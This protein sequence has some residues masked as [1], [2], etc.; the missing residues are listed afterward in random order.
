MLF[1]NVVIIFIILIFVYIITYQFIPDENLVSKDH[2]IQSNIL[3]HT[4]ND[5]VHKRQYVIDNQEGTF[6]KKEYDMKVISHP[7]KKCIGNGTYDRRIDNCSCPPGFTYDETK[8]CTPIP[9]VP[10]ILT[11]PPIPTITKCNVGYTLDKTLNTCVSLCSSNEHFDPI[12]NVCVKNCLSNERLDPINN[13]CVADCQYGDWDSWSSCVSGSLVR[14]RTRKTTAPKN[15]GNTCAPG[16]IETDT[17]F[18]PINCSYG[19]WGNWSSCLLDNSTATRTRITY[20]PINNG[21]ACGPGSNIETDNSHCTSSCK[22]GAWSDWSA[23]QSGTRT[24]TRTLTQ[25][26]NGGAACP[27]SGTTETQSDSNTCTSQYNFIGEGGCT[28]DMNSVYNTCKNI[29]G[30]Q[31]YGQQSN[32]CWHCLQVVNSGGNKAVSSYPRGLFNKDPSNDKTNDNNP[33]YIYIGEGGCTNDR[34]SAK[35]TCK[36]IAGCNY[37]GQQFNGCWHCLK[38]VTSGGNKAASSYPQGLFDMQYI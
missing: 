6:M 4:S 16:I 3:S 19:T 30:F 11:V 13:V 21:T 12:N 2:Y 32:G 23:C 1:N 5:N 37:I 34:N 31:K 35:N 17:S 36:A 7:R 27:I 29:S 8:G 38:S 9:T 22:Y 24:R 26:I 15:G 33:Q 10:P 25:P 18:C 28:N 14:T 20:Q